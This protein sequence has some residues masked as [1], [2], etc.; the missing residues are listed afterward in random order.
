MSTK[1]QIQNADLKK[2]KDG[3]SN[4]MCDLQKS[5]INW[6]KSYIDVQQADEKK[7][8]FSKTDLCIKKGQ[9]AYDDYIQDHKCSTITR[10]TEDPPEGT[11]F[12]P[13]P[14]A[15]P[16]AITT[17]EYCDSNVM[18]NRAISVGKHVFSEC[19]DKNTPLISAVTTKPSDYN[20]ICKPYIMDYKCD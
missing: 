12:A 2:S 16:P 6:N 7:S 3:Y 14:Y 10:N 1:T 15:P 20:T 5:C 11:N 18:I 17:N 9:D 8:A 13:T 19:L 4:A